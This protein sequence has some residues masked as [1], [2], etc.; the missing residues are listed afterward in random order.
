MAVNHFKIN[1]GIS[2]VPQASSPGSPSNGD[3]YYDSGLNKFRKYENGAW[4]DF[5]GTSVDNGEFP[6]A[7]QAG[8][9][10]FVDQRAVLTAVNGTPS[11]GQFRTFDI[12]KRASIPDLAND[13]HP[14]FGIERMHTHRLVEM[15][16]EYGLNGARVFGAANDKRNLVR[17][18]GAWTNV[19]GLNG[20]MVTASLTTD[21]VEV[22]FFGTGL[23]LLTTVDANG[24][25][26]D[27]RVTVDAGSEGGSSIIVNGDDA[28]EDLGH[29]VNQAVVVTSGLSL[30]LHTVK[31]RNNSTTGINVYGIEIVDEATDITI[32][33]GISY[34]AGQKLELAAA[35]TVDYNSTFDS[36][37][38]DGSSQGSIA[39]KGGH[40]LVYQK[41]DGTIGKAIV[42]ADSTRGDMASANH[43][44]EEVIRTFFWR[45]F[46]AERGTANRADFSTLVGSRDAAF[47]M[48]D[49][50]T[51]LIGHGVAAATVLGVDTVNLT[52][53]GSLLT[54]TFVGTGVD[55][56]NYNAGAPGSHPVTIDGS[57]VGNLNTYTSGF[58]GKRLPLVSGLAYGTHVLRI[59]YSSG[60]DINVRNFTIYGPKKPTLPAGATEICSYYLMADYVA[61]STAASENIGTGVLRKH[62]L[63]E[64][65]WTGTWDTQSLTYDEIGGFEMYNGNSA[66]TAMT[67]TF[68]GTGFELRHVA[69]T[70]GHTSNVQVTANGVNLTTANFA[71]LAST[72]YG[73]SSFNTSTGILAAN[74]A[75]N[76][77]SGSSITGL[78]MDLYT[79]KFTVGSGHFFINALDI[80]TP[81]HAVKSNVTLGA[82]NTQMVGSCAL[83]DT[84]KSTPVK[85]ILPEAK[86]M[87]QAFG[88]IS[89]PTMSSATY[90]P[91]PDLSVNVKTTGGALD[92]YAGVSISNASTFANIAI[93]VNGSLVGIPVGQGTTST[94]KLLT[95]RIIVPISA[96]TH[97]IKVYWNAESASTITSVAT[98]TP[99]GPNRFLIVR[100]L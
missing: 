67:I 49:G 84:R 33:P 38:R 66:G 21:Y 76:V 11:A 5:G 61:N 73:G 95:N 72:S 82:Q 90:A 87:A 12:S 77:H 37:T 96:G 48:D 68:F 89:G 78:P 23:T 28:V 60:T 9:Q 41:S 34:A 93:Y 44:N 18:V 26:R 91:V 20:P 22:V 75:N 46:G 39:A 17:F 2:L 100:E 4:G 32:R 83:S 58:A 29:G 30:G 15:K 53:G 74:A 62:V 45:E 8:F 64:M 59:T 52:G 55:I 24:T 51:N 86:A 42:E 36:I 81:I 79:V 94:A 98:T 27:Y 99:A 80:I 1:K 70:S 10:G 65:I 56:D 13:M 14:S 57:S 97:S 19:Q 16:D 25:P 7:F 54:F 71:G 40:V 85:D 69:N 63:R 50:S 6:D 35:A 47:N 43:A 31:I 92:I 3:I 88:I